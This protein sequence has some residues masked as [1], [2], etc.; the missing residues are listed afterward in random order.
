VQRYSALRLYRAVQFGELATIALLDDR[1]YRDLQAC[2]ESGSP[3]VLDDAACPQ[4]RAVARTLLGRAQMSW[5]TQQFQ[6]SRSRWNLIAQQTL[7]APLDRDGSGGPRRYWRDG[8]DGYP[9]ERARVVDAIAAARLRNPVFLGGDV[10]AN[11]VTDIRRNVE[12]DAA[13]VI[14]TEFCGTSIT[15]ASSWNA[16]RTERAAR[17]NPH[18]RFADSTRR[19]YLLGNLTAESLRIDLRVVD[20][21]TQER[22]NVST[23]ARFMVAD[24]TA[25]AEKV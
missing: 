21:V 15:S 2:R 5:L 20:D 11:W 8:W 22:P 14:A 10:H 25:G 4:R 17:A 24:G 3:A 18:V 19:G 23:L 16:E 6:A 1:Q 7:F 12:D 9:A 13:P